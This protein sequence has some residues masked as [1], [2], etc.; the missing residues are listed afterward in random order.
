MTHK[1]FTQESDGN[2][3]T[4]CQLSNY[5]P[6]GMRGFVT[7]GLI[8]ICPYVGGGPEGGNARGKV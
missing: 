8:A 1:V 7:Y 5:G 4:I 6:S 3:W 2:S